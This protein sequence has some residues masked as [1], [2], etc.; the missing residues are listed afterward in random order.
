MAHGARNPKRTGKVTRTPYEQDRL[1]DLTE[2]EREIMSVVSRSK[3]VQ[4]GGLLVTPHAMAGFEVSQHVRPELG[5]R[6]KHPWIKPA[7][8]RT[9]AGSFVLAVALSYLACGCSSVA[10]RTVGVR[11]LPPVSSADQVKVV[12]RDQTLN[13]PYQIVGKV[14]VTRKGFLG[15]PQTADNDTLQMRTVAARMG[16]DGLVG[17]YDGLARQVPSSYRYVKGTE[18]PV[19][20][21]PE[22]ALLNDY[23]FRSGLA[24][25]WLGP[26]EKRSQDFLPFVIAV[27]PVP[28]G[29]SSARD[30]AKTCEA[31]R[32]AIAGSLESRGY[33][34]LPSASITFGEGLEGVRQL[35][36]LDAPG[37]GGP[38]AQL[39]CEAVITDSKEMNILPLSLEVTT[40][41]KA[42]LVEKKTGRVV[43]QGVGRAFAK[44][45]LTSNADAIR[46]E[47]AANAVRASL[48]RLEAVHELAPK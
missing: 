14:M 41:V 43:F 40:E 9:S 48:Y 7:P 20:L 39:V 33:Y 23:G 17:L 27:L 45:T 5:F 35:K 18:P 31:I 12:G 16:A 3:T 1:L 22:S 26:G 44:D 8:W 37:L 29:A 11:G 13:E 46:S 34:V 30:P 28:V 24:V 10:T 25:K 21:Y 15:P 19:N 4:V 38:D 2:N 32:L 6:E 42:T 47:A 36:G